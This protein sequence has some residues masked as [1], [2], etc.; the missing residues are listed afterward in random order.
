MREQAE[1]VDTCWDVQQVSGLPSIK[2]F[3]PT[4]LSSVELTLQDKDQSYDT[5]A[6]DEKLRA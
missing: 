1:D 4:D 3:L 5:D 2:N 6:I